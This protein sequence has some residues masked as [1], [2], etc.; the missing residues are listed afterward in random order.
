VA[1]HEEIREQMK[2]ALQTL[3][4]R[5]YA[6]ISRRQRQEHER[7]RQSIFK[8]Y[9]GEVAKDLSLLTGQD[10][11]ALLTN[12]LES[13]KHAK[14]KGSPENEQEGEPE[15]AKL[16]AAPELFEAAISPFSDKPISEKVK[17]TAKPKKDKIL[18]KDQHTLDTFFR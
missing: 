17:K 10:E 5:L 13:A 14:K 1:Y 8:I 11:A 9:A 15:P 2:L 12:L 4:R 16:T 18:K 6:F 3:G 7:H